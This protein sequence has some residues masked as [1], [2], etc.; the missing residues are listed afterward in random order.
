MRDKVNGLKEKHARR[1]NSTPSTQNISRIDMRKS[2]RLGN[3][4]TTLSSR[5]LPKP[6]LLKEKGMSKRSKR[7]QERLSCSKSRHR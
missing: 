3:L 1:R 5:P 6:L 4:L 7:P 2:L